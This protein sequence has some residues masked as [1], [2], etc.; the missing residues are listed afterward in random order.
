MPTPR[1]SFG[2]AV[3]GSLVYVVGGDDGLQGRPWTDVVEVL[4]TVAGVWST[5]APLPRP[6]VS[7]GVA[8]FGNLLYV[9]GGSENSVD[10]LDT[11][12]GAWRTLEP[13]TPLPGDVLTQPTDE[14]EV[15]C[16]YKEQPGV[17]YT[18]GEV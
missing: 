7:H 1:V 6:R 14:D 10:V 5:L 8:V 2:V 16:E 15:L 17:R 13:G 4:D 18:S 9:I 3:V 11:V 12:S